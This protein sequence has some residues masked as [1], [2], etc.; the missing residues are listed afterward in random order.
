MSKYPS[1]ATV[2]Y[3]AAGKKNGVALYV[4]MW[5]SPWDIVEHKGKLQKYI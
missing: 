1:T 5:N 4:H 3:Y 2:E